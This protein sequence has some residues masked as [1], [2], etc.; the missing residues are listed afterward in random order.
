MIAMR[1]FD[2][3]GGGG[4]GGGGGFSEFFSPFCSYIDS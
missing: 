3:R 2:L 1:G 4:G